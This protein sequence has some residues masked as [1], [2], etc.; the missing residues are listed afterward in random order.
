LKA[1]EQAVVAAFWSV[2]LLE[3]VCGLVQTISRDHHVTPYDALYIELAMRFGCPLA[4][5]D[6]N[7]LSAA[8]ALEVECL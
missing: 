5:L 8:R 3:Q 1:G 4:T 2:E 6:R 7:Q